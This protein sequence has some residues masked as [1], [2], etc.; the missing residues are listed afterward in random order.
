MAQL[1]HTAEFDVAGTPDRMLA[2]LAC[3]ACGYRDPGEAYRVRPGNRVRFFCDCCGAFVTIQ[4][5]D[6][7][8]RVVR[9]WCV[10]GSSGGPMAGAQDLKRH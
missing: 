3:P 1:M 10:A 9:D 6:A 2:D 4:L 8:A 7:Q 5:S